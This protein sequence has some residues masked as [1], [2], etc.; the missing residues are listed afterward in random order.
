M[1]CSAFLMESR[2]FFNRR[3]T[4][5]EKEIANLVDV[6]AAGGHVWAPLPRPYNRGVLANYSKLVQSASN[7]AVLE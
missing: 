5:L 4:S 1:R 2:A 3:I 6:L 7:G